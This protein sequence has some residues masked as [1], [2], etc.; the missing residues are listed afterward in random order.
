M[1]DA[2]LLIGFG[3]PSRSEEIRP[4]LDHILR[5]RPIPQERYEEVVHHYEVMGGGSPYNAHTMRQADA[6]RARLR[7]DGIEIP[8]VVGMRNWN[9]YILD[10]M[11]KLTASHATK[12]LGF[13]LAA[14][15]C[16]ASWERYQAAVDAARATIGP[17]APQIEYPAPWHTHPKFVEAAADRTREA[18]SR[19]D[20][21]EANRAD[22]IFT[23]HSIPVPMSTASGYADQIRASAAAVTARLGRESWTLAFQS[24]SGAPRDPWLEPDISEVIRKLDGRPAVV[25][26]LGFLCDHVEVMYDLDVEAGKTARACGTKMIRAGTVGDHPAFIEMMAEIVRRHVAR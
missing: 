8:V 3:G 18:F 11:R 4:F 9:P 22:L 16:E 10:T 13:V 1:I 14:H 2:V 26:P 19:L 25:M 12:A 6:L 24:R 20:Q 7:G 15:R 5:G 17:D 21:N 23:A